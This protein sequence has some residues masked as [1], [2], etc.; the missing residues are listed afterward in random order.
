MGGSAEDAPTRTC[1]L[2]RRIRQRSCEVAG[3]GSLRRKAWQRLCDRRKISGG[4]CV[5]EVVTSG[6]NQREYLCDGGSLNR[7]VV[8]ESKAI[9]ARAT[10]LHYVPRCASL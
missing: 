2:D 6:D 4:G 8:D 10:V 1:R 9:H 3:N 5:R 7:R